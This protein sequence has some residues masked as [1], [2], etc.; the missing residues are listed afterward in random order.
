LAVE[1]TLEAGTVGT[2][3]VELP[4]QAMA[5]YQQGEVAKFL[6]TASADGVPNVALIVSQTPVEPGK[7]AFG[8]FMMVKTKENLDANHRVASLAMTEKLEM[9]GFKGDF[10]GWTEGGPY[11]AL[12]NSIAF[13]RYNAYMGIR[14]VAALEIRRMIPMPEKVSFLKVG[15]DFAAMRTRGRLGRGEPV[16]GVATPAPV[17]E[18]FDGIMSIKVLAYLDSDGYPDMAPLFGVMF[19]TPGELRFKLSGYNKRLEAIK[20]GSSIALNVLTLDLLTYQLKGTLVRFDDHL[21]MKVGVVRVEEVYSSMPPL[22]A[23][24]LA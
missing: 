3:T 21:G 7:L 24:R 6:A 15:L 11:E 14:N 5:I 23:E 10:M 22:V 8:E 19:R 18:K 1:S 4:P 16:G 12:I 17:R 13:F 20:P 9:A 2:R